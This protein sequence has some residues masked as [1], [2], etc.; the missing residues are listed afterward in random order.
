M[1]RVF[2]G[3][4]ALLLPLSSTAQL[5]DSP[6]IRYQDL[7]HPVFGS[8]GMVAAQNSLSAEAGAEKEGS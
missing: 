4:C 3:I 6:V 8:S 7:S 5:T 1:N 2:A